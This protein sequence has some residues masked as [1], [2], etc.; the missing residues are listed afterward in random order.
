MKTKDMLIACI[1]LTFVGLLTYVWLT[2]SGVQSPTHV[3]F[4]TLDGETID[5]QSLRSR[6]LLVN[7]WATSCVACVDEM[8]GLAA[9]Y[10]DLNPQG[11]EIIA[12]AA[13]YDPP[14]HVLEFVEQFDIPFPVSLD[15][16]DAIVDAFGGLKL[17]PTSYLINA[18]GK[19][20]F[21]KLGELDLPKLRQDIE[22]LL[23]QEA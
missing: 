3:A 6:P 22:Q 1:T 8:P 17:V 19:I 23:A 11:L 2:P 12:V 7:F 9:I 4:K 18:D 5:I 16:D 10:H 13:S 15:I 20:V 21:S 14:N